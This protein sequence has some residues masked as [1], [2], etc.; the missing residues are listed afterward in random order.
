MFA[1]SRATLVLVAGAVDG[2]GGDVAGTLAP[3]AATLQSPARVSA[4]TAIVLLM[5]TS[6]FLGD[7]KEAS[8]NGQCG[9]PARCP[10]W[11]VLRMPDRCG[12]A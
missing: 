7:A 4:A 6:F 9:R 11:D 2:S 3:H 12:L 5:S 1:I 8:V 10:V